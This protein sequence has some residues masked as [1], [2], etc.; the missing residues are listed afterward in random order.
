MNKSEINITVE[1]DESKHP[2]NMEWTATDSGMDGTR[3]CKGL[4]ISLW[5]GNDECTY[6]IDLWTKT[7]MVEEM[8]HMMYET[9]RGMADTY[10]KATGDDEVTEA[11]NEFAQNFGKLAGVLK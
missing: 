1:L 3:P 5:D 4:M 2:V 8:Q 10:Q 9:I 6:R 7:M 11:M